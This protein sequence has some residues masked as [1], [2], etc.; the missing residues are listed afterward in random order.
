MKRFFRTAV[1]LLY[2]F[3]KALVV[4]FIGILARIGKVIS[5][6]YELGDEVL[7]TIDKSEDSV[8]NWAKN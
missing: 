1:A 4:L 8:W 7:D 6:N 5:R 3:A 2:T